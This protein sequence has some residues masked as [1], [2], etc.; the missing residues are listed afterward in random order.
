[1]ID[2]N[3]VIIG[4]LAFD[5]NAFYFENSNAVVN[6]TNIGGACFYSAIPSSM[7]SKVGIVSRIGQDFKY[8]YF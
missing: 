3:T 2:F 6:R 7:F 8:G 1:M 5:V 4:N